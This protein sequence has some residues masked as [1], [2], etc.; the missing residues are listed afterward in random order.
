MLHEKIIRKVDT[1]NNRIPIKKIFFLPTMSPS[2]PKGRRNIAEDKM[3]LL[4]TQ[5]RPMAFA[6]NSLPIDGSAK[7]AAELRKGTRKAAKA[8]TRSTDF[9]NELLS[10]S[11]EF[12]IFSY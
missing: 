4:M 8:E 9:L 2:L 11:S 5:P 1:V 10:L 6:W 3:K 12:M 7:L